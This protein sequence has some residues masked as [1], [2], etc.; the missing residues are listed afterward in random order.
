MTHFS[1]LEEAAKLQL[2]RNANYTFSVYDLRHILGIDARYFGKLPRKRL[3][4]LDLEGHR[5][6]EDWYQITCLGG[7]K[8][9]MA[10]LCPPQF[11]RQPTFKQQETVAETNL[12]TRGIQDDEPIH[13]LFVYPTRRRKV[14][15]NL[16][17][18]DYTTQD[19]SEEI[20]WTPDSYNEGYWGARWVD[21]K[22]LDEIK[23][24][25]F[26]LVPM[27]RNRLRH[28]AYPARVGLI[29]YVY[30]IPWQTPTD[31]RITVAAPFN[32]VAFQPMSTWTL[33]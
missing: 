6:V 5:H 12:E 28:K 13:R 17:Y 24:L 3:I 27:K 2:N 8:P 16:Q 20:K 15:K 9:L 19:I 30:D 32:D 33:L 31:Q 10:R 18:I 25:G 21:D 23:D 4:I 29:G 11:S 14:V 7:P 22:R 26:H 1:E